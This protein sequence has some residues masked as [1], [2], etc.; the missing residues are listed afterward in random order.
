M[1]RV[2]R[3]RARVFLGLFAFVLVLFSMRLFKLQI[4]DTKGDTD[5]A[6]V[7]S[8]ITTVRASRGDILD[9]NGN[10][11]V[12]NRASYNL[13][14]NHY[15]TKSNPNCNQA[16][17]DL[18]Q[19]CKELGIT[20][21]DHFPVSATRPFTYTLTEF[22]TSWQN[23][24]QLFMVDRGL[25]SDIT[26]PLLVEKMRKRYEIP[27]EWSDEDARA[28]IGFRYEFDLRGIT[29]LPTY[30]FLEDVTDQQLSA[31]LELN[32]PGLNVEAST[33]REYHTKYA[34]HILGY[35]GGMNDEQWEEYK[36]QGYSM[37]AKV[38]QTG[39]ELA[40]E[41]YL[42]GIDGTRYDEVNK[43]GAT[44]KSYYTKD[45]IAGNSVETTIDIK[46]Q[47]VAEKALDQVMHKIVDPEQREAGDD[48]AG[49]D[50]QGAAVVVMECQTGKILA[51][52]SYPT[53]NL[54]TMYEDWDDIM[55]DD[56]KPFFNRAFGAEYPPGSSFKMCTLISAM[57]HRNSKGEYI[58]NYGEKIE[59]K[60]VFTK[61]EGFAPTC[62]AWTSGHFVHT[63]ADGSPGGIDATDALCYSCNYFFYVL[64]DL[65]TWENMEETCKALGLGV[66][67]GIELVEK[68]GRI[69]TPDVKRKV[70]GS[71]V[72]GNFSAGD[73][74]LGA[75]GQ[76]ENRFT[77]MQLAVYASTLANKGTRMKA[78]FLSR[79][80]SSDYRTLIKENQPEIANQLE[81]APTT[82]ESYWKGMRK[83]ITQMGGT[84]TAY[85]G[86]P[87]DLYGE[88]D[89]VWPL[90]DEVI[91]YA[92]T[93]TAEHASLGS[94]HGAFIC[95]AHRKDDPQPDIA[96]ALY[97]E[98]VA[99]GSWLAPVAEQIL[100]SYYEMD[101]ASEV[102]AFE[103]QVG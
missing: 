31:I 49:L 8:T 96:V 68:T 32:T 44:T 66:P 2:S 34:A 99:H 42:H 38:G 70:Y 47:E 71:G 43:D 74:V 85:F 93:G 83:V 81:M 76:G 11:L 23:N 6:Q 55:K 97:G 54:A 102:T 61:Y 4:I 16:L 24:F 56:L 77:P 103:N 29:N 19:K 36:K 12:G 57:E 59:D 13:V 95:F 26:A 89:G 63:A 39:F 86:G 50:A 88:G 5:N 58:Y 87:K 9:R 30:T 78:T 48:G 27:D 53:F 98:K 91:V 1:E 73:R 37:D 46:I 10:V 41:E 17:F 79:V 20:Y 22:N 52:A 35:L 67:T 92:K 7:Y 21:T 90:K 18:V 62:L 40:F 3:V 65:N 14:F 80:V 101:A 33:V 75:I 28:V 64:G 100:L 25:D 69:N 84:A 82:I 60:G 51:C 45:P 15:V 94:D 72:N